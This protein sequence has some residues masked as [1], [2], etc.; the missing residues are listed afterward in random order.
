MERAIEHRFYTIS[1]K[2]LDTQ[3]NKNTI[4]FTRRLAALFET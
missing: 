1:T 4:I 2:A 3:Q